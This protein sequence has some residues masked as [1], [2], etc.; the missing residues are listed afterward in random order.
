[1]PRCNIESGATN[2]RLV[3][4]FCAFAAEYLGK[5]V[6]HFALCSFDAL[7]FPKMGRMTSNARV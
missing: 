7:S 4:R 3:P 6:Q 5:A 2:R 1:L